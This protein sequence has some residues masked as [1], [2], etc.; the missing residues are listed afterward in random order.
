MFHFVETLF[1]KRKDV[2]TRMIEKMLYLIEIIFDQFT[3][4]TPPNNI[5]KCVS[6]FINFKRLFHTIIRF[7]INGSD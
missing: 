3:K 1:S 6:I 4:I 2:S 7:T 5:E